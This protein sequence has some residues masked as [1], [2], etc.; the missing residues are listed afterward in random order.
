[1]QDL[2]LLDEILDRASHVFNW[3]VRVD[4][5]L[6]IEVDAVGPEA[7]ERALDDFP[8][9]LR[10][11]VEVTGFKIET[12]L[13]GD[14]D[15]VADRRERFADKVFVR[16]GAVDFGRIKEGDAFLMGLADD[17]NALSSVR[18]GTVV[19]ADAHAAQSEC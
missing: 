13:T 11:A 2:S 15:L 4:P 3:N 8:D 7:L 1:M 14:D 18:R 10:S 16:V 6:V 5:V 9:V 19:G 12:E 17:R